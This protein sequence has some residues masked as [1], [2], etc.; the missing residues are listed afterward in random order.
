AGPPH[1]RE[2]RIRDATS[3]ALLQSQRWLRDAASGRRSLLSEQLAQAS[4]GQLLTVELVF[5]KPMRY[6]DA[7]GTVASL[8]G[9][10]TA[11]APVVRRLIDGGG[12]EMLDTLQG[13]WLAEDGFDRYRDDTFRFSWTPL[14]SG[15]VKLEVVTTDMAGLGLDADPATPVD[16]QDGAWS[17]WEDAAGSDGDTGGAD[18][19]TAS[20]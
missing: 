16:W 20:L 18:R 13:S 11:T 6:R 1:L 3:G 12:S 9:L 2:V 4:A 15:S 14:S 8:P 7:N 19:L 17:E 5:N 10:S